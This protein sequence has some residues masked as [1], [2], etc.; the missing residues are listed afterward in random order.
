MGGLRHAPTDLEHQHPHPHV[1]A[2]L[3]AHQHS[4]RRPAY[5]AR[6]ALGH[7]GHAALSRL[8]RRRLLVHHSHRRWWPGLAAPDRAAVHHQCLQVPRQRPH[9]SRQAHQRPSP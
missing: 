3:D 9:H 5:Q 6:A 2:D 7:P 4:A 1:H 8:L